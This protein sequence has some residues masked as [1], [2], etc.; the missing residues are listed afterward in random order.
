[1]RYTKHLWVGAL[2]LALG[3]AACADLA[4]TNPNAPDA[5]RAIKSA[6]DVENLVSGGYNTWFNGVYSYYGPPLM[7]AN[8]AFQHTAPWA[9]GG[10]EQYGRLPRI[11]IVNDAADVYYPNWTRPWYYCYRAISGVANG[12]AAMAKPEISAQIAASDLTRDKAFGYFTLGVAHGTIALLYDQGFQVDETTDVNKAQSAKD[13]KALMT[14]ALGYFDKALTLTNGASFTIPTGWMGTDAEVSAATFAKLIHSMKARFMVEVARTPADRAAVNWAT[15]ITEVNAGITADFVTKQDVNNGWENDGLYYGLAPGWSEAA[16]FVWGMADQSGNYQLWL[17]TP[18]GNRQ[19]IIGGKDILIVTPDQRFPQ[20]TDVTSQTANRGKYL[21]IPTDDQDG[22]TPAGGWARPDRG[23]WRWSYYYFIRFEGY[24]NEAD[25]HVP[26]VPI[27]EMNMLK[28]EGL[29][30]QGDKAGAAAL[31]NISRVAIGGLN[32]TDANGTNTSC[33][34]KL[35]TGSC[36][37]LMEMIKWEKRVEGAYQGL[38]SVPWYFDGRGW[39][40]LY[41]GTPLQW[42]APCKELQVLQM[43]PCYS[44]GGSTDTKFGAPLSSYAYPGENS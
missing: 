1:M 8:A 15:V 34:P 3:T 41:K 2:C 25:F 43:L 9:N 14:A 12:L 39:G 30:R 16:Y 22:T 36:G 40:D 20:G 37:N 13:Y 18:L 29:Y 35:P 23:S 6:G 17:N 38:L 32:A 31:V 19:A 44:F 42:P 27:S 5:T 33:V 4:V 28:A 21:A 11:G 7:L 10:M 24:P 26:E